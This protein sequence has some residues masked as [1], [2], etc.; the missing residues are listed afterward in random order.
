MHFE[1]QSAVFSGA[2]GTNGELAKPFKNIK[3]SSMYV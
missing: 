2:D 3:Y 1:P